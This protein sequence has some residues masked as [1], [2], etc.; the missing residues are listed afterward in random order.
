MT[1]TM[2]VEEARR[3]LAQFDAEARAQ[4][5]ARE[6]EIAAEHAR[7]TARR[8]RWA[9]TYEPTADLNAAHAAR[10]AARAAFLDALAAEPWVQALIAWQQAQNEPAAAVARASHAHVALGQSVNTDDRGPNPLVEY[11]N[12]VPSMPTILRA[13]AA[14][15]ADAAPH[16]PMAA[17]DAWVAAPDDTNLPMPA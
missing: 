14:L 1:D 10:H 9:E 17:V 11:I 12:N 3:V 7:Q 4:A 2:R 6:R 8:R 15:L 13:L 5:E 16:E